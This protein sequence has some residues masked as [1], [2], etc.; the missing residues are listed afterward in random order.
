M[1]SALLRFYEL[2]QGRAFLVV[3]RKT[4]AVKRVGGSLEDVVQ[5]QPLR[6]CLV[7]RSCAQRERSVG[8]RQRARLCV[9]RVAKAHVV[10]AREARRLAALERKRD[11]AL[12]R[13]DRVARVRRSEFP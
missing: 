2:Q 12:L 3:Q 13:D 7:F 5:E 9:R 8:K 6:L 11:I 1:V 10:D 4:V